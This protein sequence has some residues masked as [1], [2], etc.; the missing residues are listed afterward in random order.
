MVARVLEPPQPGTFTQENHPGSVK[1][2]ALTPQTPLLRT[3]ALC[4]LCGVIGM[5]VGSA[6]LST[7]FLADG[8]AELIACIPIILTAVC[9]LTGWVGAFSLMVREEPSKPSR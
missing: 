5:V 3:I 8:T 4:M 6:G 9:I 1:E 2:P 7:A